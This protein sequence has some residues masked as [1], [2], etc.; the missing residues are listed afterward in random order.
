M[1]PAIHWILRVGLAALMAV[2]AIHKARDPA[3]FARTVRDYRIVPGPLA[4]PAAATAW[5]CEIVVAVALLLPGPVAPAAS[6]C[7]ALLLVYSAAIATNLARGRRHID[8]GCLGPRARQSI[9]PALLV[10][11]GV[12][13]A[14]CILAALPP[15]DRALTWLDGVTVVGGLTVVALLFQATPALAGEASRLRRST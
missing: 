8:C 3:G 14:A 13:V 7:A 1:D 6:A 12:L 2:A 11:N 10:R 4:A 5:I 15:S 9:T